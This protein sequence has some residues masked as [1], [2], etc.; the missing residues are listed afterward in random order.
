MKINDYLHKRA[1]KPIRVDIKQSLWETL[2]KMRLTKTSFALIYKN[3]QLK[4]FYSEKRHCKL[5]SENKGLS[6]RNSM[7]N[8]STEDVY[9]IKPEQEVELAIRFMQIK[10]LKCMPVFDNG[11]LL[12]ILDLNHA[13]EDLIED[14]NHLVKLLEQFISGSVFSNYS[15]IPVERDQNSVLEIFRTQKMKIKE[16][17]H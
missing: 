11:K 16:F 2:K 4:G 12:G 13:I 17:D 5:L 15:S 10:E 1:K 6:P 7:E 9:Y 3:D 8:I 14:R